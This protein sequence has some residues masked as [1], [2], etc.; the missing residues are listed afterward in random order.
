MAQQE[1]MIDKPDNDNDLRTIYRLQSGVQF[2]NVRLGNG[3]LV[4]EQQASS[5]GNNDINDAVVL[6]HINAFLSNNQVLFDTRQ[7]GRPI[8]YTLGSAALAFNKP[9]LVTPGLDDALLSRGTLRPV[10]P[11]ADS[12]SEQPLPPPPPMRQGG[13]RLVVVPAALA[14]GD[15]GVSRYQILTQ[16]NGRLSQ[17]V[18]RNEP[19]KYEIEVLRCM[20]VTTTTTVSNTEEQE[21]NGTSTPRS[22]GTAPIAQVCCSEEVYPCQVLVP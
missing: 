14:Y 17:P 21:V 10:V 11:L 6:L 3:P 20:P 2:R 22:S 5:K 1:T 15:A 8:Q 4:T 13:I 18:P 7:D 9:Q 12:T 16:L 19:I